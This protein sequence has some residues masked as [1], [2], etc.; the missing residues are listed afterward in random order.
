MALTVIN[1]DKPGADK[2][3]TFEA[4]LHSYFNVSDVTQISV[5]GLEGAAYHDKVDQGKIKQQV[6]AIKFGLGEHGLCQVRS[7]HL[8]NFDHHA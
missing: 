5:V 2:A 6:D 4:A 1:R 3:I 7:S 8:R